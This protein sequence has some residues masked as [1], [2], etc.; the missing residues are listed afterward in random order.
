MKLKAIRP[1]LVDGRVVGVGEL[2]E[3]GDRLGRE[4]VAWGK[5]VPAPNAPPDKP[6]KGAMTT[7]TAT[8]LVKGAGD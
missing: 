5:A 1:H 7:D 6:K 8:A 3:T 2:Y 4:L